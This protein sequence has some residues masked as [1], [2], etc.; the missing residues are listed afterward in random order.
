VWEC[1]SR[2][3]I[4][5]APTPFAKMAGVCLP[6]KSL[7]LTLLALVPAR[8]SVCCRWLASVVSCIVSLSDLI[9]HLG[10]NVLDG[11]ALECLNVP[12]TDG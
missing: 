4:R 11:T 12:W 1:W 7:S 2:Q 9:S 8:T 3:A 10:W 5:A 6:L